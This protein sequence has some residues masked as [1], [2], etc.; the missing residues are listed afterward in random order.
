M[1]DFMASQSF[2]SEQ[3]QLGSINR[4]WQTCLE[5]CLESAGVLLMVWLNHRSI[6]SDERI[7]LVLGFCWLRIGKVL[8]ALN[9]QIIPG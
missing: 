8:C 6:M 3:Q 4:E 2:Q 1:G 5:V 9:D 7:G